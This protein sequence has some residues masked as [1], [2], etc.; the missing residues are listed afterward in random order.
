MGAVRWEFGRGEG[1]LMGD[2]SHSLDRHEYQQHPDTIDIC[3]SVFNAEYNL[4][5][6]VYG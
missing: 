1:R 4:A 6:L 5:A 2:F 3:Y